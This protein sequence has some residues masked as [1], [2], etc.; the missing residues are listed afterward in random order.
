[1]EGDFVYVDPCCGLEKGRTDLS[2]NGHATTS[3]SKKKE[4]DEVGLC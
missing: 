2:K 3:G 1:M 4:E